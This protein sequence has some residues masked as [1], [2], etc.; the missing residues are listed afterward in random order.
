V[1]DD[2]DQLRSQSDVTVTL[3][4]LTLTDGTNH[5]DWIAGES[6]MLNSIST[7]KCS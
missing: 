6:D 1:H 5:D 7:K 4:T 3:L 2:T